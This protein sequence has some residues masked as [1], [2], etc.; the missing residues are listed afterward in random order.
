MTRDQLYRLLTPLARPLLGIHPTTITVA[1]LALAVGAGAAYA[2]TRLD[3]RFYFAGAA[4]VL[5]SGLADAFD[6][7]VARLTDTTSPLGDFL[8]HFFDRLAEVAILA[9]LAVSRDATPWLG[10]VAVVLVVLN[11]YLGTQIEASF[12]RRDYSGLGRGQLVAGLVL[13]SLILGLDLGWSLAVGR[14]DLAFVDLV[15]VGVSLLTAVAMVQ[16][17]RLAARLARGPAE[18]R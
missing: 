3:P 15:L 4:L 17:L 13:A 18:P 16:R 11:A 6:G 5:L 14:W 12:G 7:L 10:T 9:G 1:A 2:A 8:D